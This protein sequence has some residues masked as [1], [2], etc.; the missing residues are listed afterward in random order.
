[1]AAKPAG[2]AAAHDSEDASASTG[3]AIIGVDT[4]APPSVELLSYYRAR[5][6]EVRQ[7]A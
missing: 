5:I 7:N 3:K 4:D 6:E 1:M 2:G